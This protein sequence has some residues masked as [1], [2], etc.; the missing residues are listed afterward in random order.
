M[1][2]VLAFGEALWDHLPRGRF[3]GGAPLNVFYHLAR[4]GVG[5]TLVSSIGRDA[6]GEPIFRL[7]APVAWGE[8]EVESVAAHLASLPE[9]LL[10][11][12]LP[13]RS[14]ST[15]RALDRLLE[16]FPEATVVRDLN[17]RPPEACWR[18]PENRVRG[19]SFPPPPHIV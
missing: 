3:L 6:A 8:I 1:S 9:V 16:L 15:R 5:S 4:L 11:G 17:L 7:A 10:F 2:Q 12:S 18:G 13:L 19:D 14:A